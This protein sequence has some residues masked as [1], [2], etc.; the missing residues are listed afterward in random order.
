M[1]GR[2]FTCKH[3]DRLDAEGHGVGNCLLA[4]NENGWS[5]PEGKRTLAFATPS[6][7]S[8]RWANLRTQ[9]NFGCVQWQQGG[10]ER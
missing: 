10:D 8:D 3:W 7:P 6:G 5:A 2:C 1:N 9:P 4:Q